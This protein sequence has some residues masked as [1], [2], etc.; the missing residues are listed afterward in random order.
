MRLLNQHSRSSGVE[1]SSAGAKR[2]RE[3]DPVRTGRR[4]SDRMTSGGIGY[5]LFFLVAFLTL[6]MLLIWPVFPYVTLAILLAYLFYPLTRRMKRVLPSA[7]A[8]A[9]LLT[10]FAVVAF[11]IP[12][13]FAIQQ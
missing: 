10:L 11:A 13:V 6:A 9:A 4:Q 1:P 5:F 8:R 12:L 7:G 2:R 3:A